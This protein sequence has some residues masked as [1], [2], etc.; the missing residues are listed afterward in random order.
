MT[1]RFDSLNEEVWGHFKDFQFIF[2]ATCE[3]DQ[4]RVRPVTLVCLDGR[5]WILT[6]TNNAKT[7]QIRKNPKMEFCLLLEKGENRGYIRG[8]GWAQ[9]V[10]DRETRAKI[11]KHC[12]LFSDYYNSSE[13]PNYTLM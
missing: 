2:L 6:G 10:K 12:N 13:D 1:K 8:A 3:R 5:F 4:P 11:A 9:I 7:K